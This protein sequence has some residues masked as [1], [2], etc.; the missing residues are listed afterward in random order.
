[1][2]FFETEPAVALGACIAV[3]DALLVLAVSFGAPISPDQKLQIDAVLAALAPLIAG[4]IIRSQVTPVAMLPHP[5]E[6]AMAA[7]EPGVHA[8]SMVPTD[9]TKPVA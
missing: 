2:S 1:M 9:P 5:L 6:V 7:T 3:L 8:P 4:V